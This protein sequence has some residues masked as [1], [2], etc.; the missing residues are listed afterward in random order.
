MNANFYSMGVVPTPYVT[1]PI[2]CRD[3]LDAVAA[4][5]RLM[6]LDG[7]GAPSESVVFGAAPLGGHLGLDR[8]EALTYF[9]LQ[10][11]ACASIVLCFL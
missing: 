8:W 3:E 1:G 7:R 10:L 11:A 5:E 4:Q 2:Q 9:A 6:P